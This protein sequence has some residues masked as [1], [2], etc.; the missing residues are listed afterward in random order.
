MPF[1]Y[2]M[3]YILQLRRNVKKKEN[4]EHFMI[5]IRKFGLFLQGYSH[6]IWLRKRKQGWLFSWQGPYLHY[7]LAQQKTAASLRG[8]EAIAS[9]A[10]VYGDEGRRWSYTSSPDTLACRRHRW[11]PP[12]AAAQ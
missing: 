10:A 3:T 4:S 5:L 12:A 1:F 6:I 9:A 2:E 7:V 8:R 11:P